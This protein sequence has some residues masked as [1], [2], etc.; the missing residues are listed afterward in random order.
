MYPACRYIKGDTKSL[1][2]NTNAEYNLLSFLRIK[3]RNIFPTEKKSKD[4]SHKNLIPIFH[5]KENWGNLIHRI[6][7]CHNL[8][9]LIINY[10]RFDFNNFQRRK[11]Q[12]HVLMFHLMVLLIIIRFLFNF[13]THLF[14]NLFSVRW[15]STSILDI[16]HSSLKS[17]FAHRSSNGNVN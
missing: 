8:K 6:L 11:I 1:V 16:S 2:W 7:F 5:I 14:L 10:T 12:F 9:R 17:H 15:K 4:F 13:H 3:K